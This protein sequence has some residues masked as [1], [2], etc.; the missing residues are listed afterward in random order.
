MR[1]EVEWHSELKVHHR[2]HPANNP[3][4]AAQCGKTEGTVLEYALRKIL[5]TSGKSVNRRMLPN[6]LKQPW[7]KR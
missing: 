4:M 2:Q 1:P 7:N 5:Q 6:S 3:G